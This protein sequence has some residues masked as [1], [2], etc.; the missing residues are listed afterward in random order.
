MCSNCSLVKVDPCRHPRPLR[1]WSVGYV[2]AL[3]TE[4]LATSYDS[5]RPALFHTTTVLGVGD[6]CRLLQQY[7]V[8]PKVSAL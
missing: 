2:A 5:W 7:L 3:A 6:G 8:G 4:R 1:H